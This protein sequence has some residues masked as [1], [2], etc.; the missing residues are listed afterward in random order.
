MSNK[1]SLRARGAVV[2]RC[3]DTTLT[4]A[5]APACT[6]RLS[7]DADVP[8]VRLGGAQHDASDIHGP[9]R[10]LRWFRTVR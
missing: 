6:R 10:L 9:C 2:A 4:A 7:R 1:K 5:N 8:E 3:C